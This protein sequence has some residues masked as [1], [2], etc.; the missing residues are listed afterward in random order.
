[1]EYFPPKAHI[2]I[3][4]QIFDFELWHC[5]PSSLPPAGPAGAERQFDLCY[6]G[7]MGSN[8]FTRHRNCLYLQNWIKKSLLFLKHIYHIHTKVS[9]FPLRAQP[10]PTGESCRVPPTL[11]LSSSPSPEQS[12]IWPL[13]PGKVP[14]SPSRA[15]LP[16]AGPVPLTWAQLPHCAGWNSKTGSSGSRR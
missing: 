13:Q 9:I 10:Q 5:L 12:C 8:S 16:Q 14:P 1:M 6:I 7:T 4:I 15:H 2:K 3:K 11:V